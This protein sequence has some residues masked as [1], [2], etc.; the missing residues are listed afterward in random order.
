M[1][2]LLVLLITGAVVA[3]IAARKRW[4]LP[5]VA[6]AQGAEIDRL[7]FVTFAIIALAFILVQ[8]ALALFIWRFRDRGQAASYWHHHPALEMTYTVIP[9]VVMVALTLMAARLWTR[10]HSPA[11]A[12][13]LMVEVRAEQFTWL[14]RY[15]GA[16]GTFGRIDA[17]QYDRQRNPMALDRG[18]PAGS[19][20]IVVTETH[21]VVNRP[22]RLR[23][24]SKDVIHSFFVPALRV[25]QDAV[26][27]ITVEI[28]FTPTRIG[29]YQAVCAELC[30]VGHYVMVRPL[31]VET[32]EVFDAWLARQV[33]RP[34]SGSLRE[35]LSMANWQP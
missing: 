28:S 29:R 10:I 1:A 34:A 26:P 16:D 21:F 14:T 15:P 23:L 19:D 7:F 31:V 6:S 18:D 35:G 20:D 5:P 30:G 17:R 2:L 27:G 11:A 8:G 22:V 3:T 13:A 4:W 25:K 12:D 9:A 33:E 32:Q 24:R